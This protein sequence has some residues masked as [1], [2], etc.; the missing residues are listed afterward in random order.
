MKRRP[1]AIVMILFIIFLAACAGGENSTGE[2]VSVK[3]GSKKSLTVD[4]S[5]D[6]VS[7]DPHAANDGTSLYVMNAMYDTLVA[8]NKDLEIEPALAESL[9]QI[10]DLV[11]EAKIR[12]G[13]KFHDGSELNAEVVKANLDRVRDPEV[14]SPLSFLFDMISTVKVIDD[15]TVQIETKFPF[16]A[17]PSHLAHPGGHMISLEAIKKDY[18]QMEDG[19]EPFTYINENPIGTGYF[20]YDKR[21]NGEFVSLVK[22]E[23]YWG[24]QAKV[25]QVTFKTVPEDA[26]RIA[27]LR[28]GEADIIYPVNPNDV[29]QTNSNKGT[30]VHETESASMSYLGMNNS[31]EPFQDKRVRQAIAMAINKQELVDGVFAGVP[32][33]ANGPL[34]STVNGHSKNVEPLG[35]D[36]EKAR[37]LLEEA[38]YET[39]FSASIL[40]YDRTTSDIAEYVQVQLEKIGIDVNIE[41][42][43]VG[44][45]LEVTGNGSFDMFIGSWGTV[46]LDADYGL[47]PMFHSQN[48]GNAGNRSFFNHKQVDELL[49][50]ARQT[51]DEQERLQFYEEAQQIIVDEATIV[52]LYHSVLLAGLREE[53]KGFYQYPSSFPFLRDVEIK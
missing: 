48:A 5:A 38:G 12:Q 20:K 45:Y 36:L 43:E 17:L 3:D 15:Y 37:E 30:A 28:T 50:K 34:A 9:E 21:V 14:G 53:V 22:N 23:A 27:E 44:A 32:L 25:D 46:T 33:V 49:E 11:W 26:S 1:L 31:K 4:L 24:E 2:G 10:D 18:Q 35:Y 13:V 8:M 47:Y 6:P 16:A 52:P 41:Q 42:A 29:K 40:A 19:G 39:G 51:S 7:L